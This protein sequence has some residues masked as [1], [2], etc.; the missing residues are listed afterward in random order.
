MSWKLVPDSASDMDDNINISEDII[1]EEV[2]LTIHADGQEYVDTKDLDPKKLLE[3]LYS[4]N[5]PSTTACPSPEMYRQAFTKDGVEN[6]LAFT[7]S[8]NLSGSYNSASLAK[9]L[10]AEEN[11]NINIHVVDSMSTGAVEYLLLEK[12]SELIKE[13]F[14]F[15]EVVEKLEQYRKETE[16][17]F[18]ISRYDNLIKNGRLNRFAGR[19]IRTFKI[20]LVG[21][22]TNGELDIIHK[23]RGEAKAIK[24][25]V[26]EMAKL[27]DLTGVN[28]VIVEVNNMAGATAMKHLMERKYPQLGTIKIVRAGGINSF[29]G[30]DQGLIVGF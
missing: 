5:T 4:T 30:E 2:P 17:L 13:G 6:V 10:V 3:T 22:E 23:V 21:K 26:D 16:T 14:S 20:L 19:L 7:L 15:P 28:V 11:P 25:L 1:V 12:A 8:H 18:I 27:K 24:T 9:Q 29:Y